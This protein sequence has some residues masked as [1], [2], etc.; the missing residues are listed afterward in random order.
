MRSAGAL[1]KAPGVDDPGE[2][3]DVAKPTSET[4][5]YTYKLRPGAQAEATLMAEW[6]RCRWLWN[7]AVH[8][9]RSGRR[10]TLCKLGKLLTEARGRFSWLRDG[11]QDAQARTLRTYC[12]AL[13][14][15]F[16][17][18]GRRR[19]KLKSRKRALPSLA[20]SRNG[21]NVSGRRL[22]LAKCPPIPIVLHRPMPSQP[23]S[24]VV[25]RDAC[26]D[27]FA[28]FV[29]RREVEPAAVAT[30]AIGID[31][32]V[33]V[34]ATT[35]DAAYDLPFAGHR[36]ASAEALAK[37]QRRMARR[38]APQ[39]KPASKGYKRARLE[40]AKLHRK[41]SRQ[42]QHTARR[43]AKSVVD[44]HQVIAV[45]DFKPKFLAKSTMAAKAADAAIGATKAELIER[46][47]RAGREVVLVPPA[48]TTMTCA[49]CGSRAKIRLALSQRTFRCESCGHSAGRDLN[50]ARTILATGE[51]IRAGADDVRHP[52]DLLSELVSVYAI[53]A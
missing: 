51:R 31:W 2:G 1:V 4:V 6:G 28:S 26:G 8:Q 15:S 43:W 9:Q 12:S 34:T 18:A 38:R 30:A 23:S 45:E 52:A 14:D 10:P 47:R 16:K 25:Y 33:R 39:G 3:T 5:R 36:K 44:N 17:V 20:Y 53:R 7:E 32:G 22:M 27:W 42:T 41:G 49:D 24:A 37:A 35:T 29:V 11:S 48:Y 50:A 21:F 40:A 46:G 13:D 19:P